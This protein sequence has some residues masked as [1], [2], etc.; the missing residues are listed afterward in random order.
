MESNYN[1]DE[2]VKQ[3]QSG[4]YIGIDFG[5]TNTAVSHVL[6]DAHGMKITYLG[7]DGEFPFPS[8][9]AMSKIDGKMIFGKE[10]KQRRNELSSD[11]KIFSSMKTLL[12]DDQEFIVNNK[13]FTAIRVTAFFL[14]YVKDYIKSNHNID[15][16][17]AII[18]CPV[19]FDSKSRKKLKVAA[20][21]AG[22]KVKG[23]IN[24]STSAYIA[25]RHL[26]KAHSKVMV[27]DWGG[28][29]IDLSILDVKGS[30]IYESSVF[31][32]RCGGDDIDLL[33]AQKMHSMLVN[34]T[35]KFVSFDEMADAERDK[36]ISNCEAM[37]LEFT[38][39]DDAQFSIR[40]YGEFGTK[41]LKIDFSYFQD[42]V[43][44]IIKDVLKAINTAMERA[45]TTKAGIDAVIL[46][47]GSCGLRPFENI[48]LDLFGP[49]K[50][51]RPDKM[52]WSVATGAAYM[53]IIGGEY[54][55]NDDVGVM[56][57]DDTVYPI[58]EKERSKVGC[59][60]TPITF[61]ITEDT[62]NA[63]F[64][65]TNG[66]KDINYGIKHVATKGFLQEELELSSEIKMDQTAK[67]TIRNKTMGSDQNTY[68]EINKLKFYYDLHQISGI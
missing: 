11:Y 61:L 58:L 60:T 16:K 36:M 35:G 56:L 6:R 63:H 66:K 4:N 3:M 1:W 18:T 27:V 12:E 50:I 28:G 2:G 17:E 34:Q 5:T 33:L 26:G 13:K 32:D 9:V 15:I 29:T 67:I 46:V 7:E 52:Q 55:L 37:K 44:P 43:T 38:L 57:S 31:G 54:Y 25:N 24:E 40:N 30:R 21:A 23:Y 49:D 42:V 53:G 10:V 19:D 48:M 8:M 45:Q 20:E 59:K 64:I 22:I 65:F 68:H 14:K 51:I 41:A 62:S 47:G 39:Y